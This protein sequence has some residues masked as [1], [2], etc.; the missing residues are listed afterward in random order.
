MEKQDH[1]KL[2]NKSHKEILSQHSQKQQSQRKLT[3]PNGKQKPMSKGS[4]LFNQ[5][6][7]LTNKI[8]H[9]DNIQQQLIHDNFQRSREGSVTS[10]K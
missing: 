4:L 5:M 8:K 1:Q 3:E 7:M 9:I 6:Q 2:N 10:K